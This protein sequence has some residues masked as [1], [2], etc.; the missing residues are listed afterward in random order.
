[1]SYL[2]RPIQGKPGSHYWG[3]GRIMMIVGRTVSWRKSHWKEKVQTS[4]ALIPDAREIQQ[5]K[6]LENKELT[7]EGGS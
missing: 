6:P 1:M 7:N 3:P 4:T 2:R 5:N